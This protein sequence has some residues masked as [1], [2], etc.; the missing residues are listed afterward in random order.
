[1]VNTWY[2]KKIAPTDS[3]TAAAAFIGWLK[4]FY[5]AVDQYFGGFSGTTATYKAYDLDDAEPRT[6]IVVDTSTLVVDSTSRAPCELALCMSY[7]AVYSSGVNKGR[8][9]GRVYLG[10]FSE[11]A[12]QDGSTGRPKTTMITAIKNAAAALLTSSQAST[13]AAWIVY[14]QVSGDESLVTGGW[15]DDDWDIQRR[16]SVLPSAYTTFGSGH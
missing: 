13:A 9:R 11:A 7:R 14:S 5:A 12:A 3:A 2:C 1:M 6:P 8:R 15:V 10:T 4:T 16:R